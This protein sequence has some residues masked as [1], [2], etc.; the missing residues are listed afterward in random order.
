MWTRGLSQVREA[1]TCARGIH[2]LVKGLPRPYPLCRAMDIVP[3]PQIRNRGWAL[4]T[5]NVQGEI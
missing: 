5:P 2:G 3:E 4:V 1:T